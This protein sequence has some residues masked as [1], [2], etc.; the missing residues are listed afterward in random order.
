MTDHGNVHFDFGRML[1]TN[2][3]GKEFKI[4]R[5]GMA[6]LYEAFFYGNVFIL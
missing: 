6:I 5:S 3:D 4:E 1:G 2:T